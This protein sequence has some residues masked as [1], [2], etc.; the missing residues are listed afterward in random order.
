MER[1]ET[2]ECDCVIDVGH[3]YK[4]SLPRVCSCFHPA[5]TVPHKCQRRH[6]SAPQATCVTV[7]DHRTL[8]IRLK[9]VQRAIWLTLQEHAP[10]S[11][12]FW[13][14]PRTVTTNICHDLRLR[15]ATKLLR[16]T[17]AYPNRPGQR[18]PQRHRCAHAHIGHH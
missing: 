18:G 4:T 3:G 17:N 8:P 16:K 5:A 14:R 15:G 2:G 7:R 1:T 12:G 11:E 6:S 13:I 10:A 9:H